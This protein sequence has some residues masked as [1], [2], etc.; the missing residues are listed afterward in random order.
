MSL[1]LKEIEVVEVLT[2]SYGLDYDFAKEIALITG[3]DMQKSKVA[4]NSFTVSKWSRDRVLESLR[5]FR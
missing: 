5:I 4:A 3:G 2:G 1:S